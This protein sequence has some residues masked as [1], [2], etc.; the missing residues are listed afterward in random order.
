L[1]TGG[2]GEDQE[3]K[4]KRKYNWHYGNTVLWYFSSFFLFS[5]FIISIKIS[6]ID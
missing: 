5:T 1:W 6:L 2:T 4:K 3:E